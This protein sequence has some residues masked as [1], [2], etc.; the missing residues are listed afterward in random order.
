MPR[1]VNTQALKSMSSMI[2]PSARPPRLDPETKEV[3]PGEVIQGSIPHREIPHQDFP[4]A[5]YLHPR[6]P[7]KKMFLPIDGHGN[8]EWRWV[9]NEVK[10]KTVQNEKELAAAQKEGWQTKVY[11]QP[12]P[13]AMDPETEEVSA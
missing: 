12:P 13:P 9:A 5:V 4:R 10:T 8:K 2:L 1:E 6:K 3:I 7:Y 11:V